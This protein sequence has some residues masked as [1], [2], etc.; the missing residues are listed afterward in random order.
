MRLA[1]KY[2]WN[3]SAAV[4]RSSLHFAA[5]EHALDCAMDLTQH[6]EAKGFDFPTDTVLIAFGPADGVFRASLEAALLAHGAERTDEP[7]KERASTSGKFVAVHVPVHVRSRAELEK[8][9][10][11]VNGVPGLKFRL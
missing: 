3:Q 4:L 8:L 6:P 9:Y 10:S 2:L 7:I 11:A 1:Y 5:T